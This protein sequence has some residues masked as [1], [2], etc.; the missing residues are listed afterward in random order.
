MKSSLYT[1]ALISGV[2]VWLIA[3]WRMIYQVVAG[4]KNL[5]S[6]SNSFFPL[7]DLF[8]HLF[9]LCVAVIGYMGSF[10]AAKVMVGHVHV[11]SS[12]PVYEGISSDQMLFIQAVSIPLI[13]AFLFLLNS[14]APE[15]VRKRIV[16]TA[17][18]WKEWC[19]GLGLGILVWPAITS[20]VWL[21]Q[22]IVSGYR[23]PMAQQAVEALLS[24]SGKP[25]FLT[26]MIVEVAL[27]VPFLE[28]VL[29]RGYLLSFLKGSLHP[30]F[31]Y[32]ASSLAF[33]WMHYSVYQQASNWAFLPALFIFGFVAALI[34]DNNNSL[35]RIVGLHSGFNA[36][37]LLFLFSGVG[38]GT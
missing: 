13:F 38:Q 37:S 33:A 25:I 28:E 7:K 21:I 2:L 3:G 5:Y 24:L 26:C 31:A 6:G 27:L 15:S 9:F 19:K 12:S 23:G 17:N 35:L 11:S 10:S 29:F 1:I 32:V 18:N 22:F 8:L 34:R 20:I 30:F 16:G 36:I 4:A 14:V